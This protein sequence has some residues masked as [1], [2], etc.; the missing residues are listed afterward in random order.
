LK[1][2]HVHGG[3]YDFFASKKLVDV[4]YAR[5]KP[6]T[7]T[8]TTTTTC[9]LAHEKQ[10]IV[11]IVFIVMLNL[12]IIDKKK[13]HEVPIVVVPMSKDSPKKIYDVQ[14]WNEIFDVELLKYFYSSILVIHIHHLL[15]FV[16]DVT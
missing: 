6:P 7:T 4:V 1:D 9:V 14:F 16:I 2:G 11:N 3:D 13:S 15:G 5:D 10:P 12:V 8:T